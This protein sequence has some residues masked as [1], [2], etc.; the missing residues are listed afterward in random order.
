MSK[1]SYQAIFGAIILILGVLLL[2]R[3]TGIYDTGQLLRFIPS[4]FI[5]LG[6]Y[7]LWRGGFSNLAGPIILIT[8]F[9]TIQLL[10]LDLISWET[11]SRWWPVLVILIGI[12]ILADRKGRSFPSRKGNETVDLFAV[13]GGVNA[14]SNS[15]NFRGG[16]ITA[17]F[18]GVDLDLR[19]SRIKDP[20][21]KI[22][23]ITMFGGVDIKVPE[24]WRIKM[25]VLPVLGGA[26]DERPRSYARK[27]TD[28]ENPDLIVTGF[29][30][31]GGFSIKD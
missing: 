8:I 14:A 17:I 27:E 23:I 25:E 13:L 30:A 28:E 26:D 24:E 31:F 21:A 22:H 12:G 16:D 1:V 7:S 29:V 11:V 3:T 10:V 15:V 19:D 6:L 18:G 9:T 2:L 4:L 20:P 5:L